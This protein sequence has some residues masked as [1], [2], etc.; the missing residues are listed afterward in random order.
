[1][2][3]VTERPANRRVVLTALTACVVMMAFVVYRIVRIAD[4]SDGTHRG[5]VLSLPLFCIASGLMV[6]MT[7]MEFNGRTVGPG[8]LIIALALFLATMLVSVAF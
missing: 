1:M 6:S 5:F 8:R 4:R 7:W 3:I 2:E